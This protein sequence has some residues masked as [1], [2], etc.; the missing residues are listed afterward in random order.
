M[1]NAQTFAQAEQWTR[2]RVGY[3]GVVPSAP[4]WVARELL[5]ELDRFRDERE[6]W[7]RENDW[8]LGVAEE[9]S[10]LR[11]QNKQLRHWLDVAARR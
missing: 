1:E 8:A 3:E 9:L 10:Q 6:V 7:R 11:A 5:A 4:F 2:D